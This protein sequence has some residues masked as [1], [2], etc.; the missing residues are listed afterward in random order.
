MPCFLCHGDTDPPSA[1]AAG[2]HT[3][4][5]SNHDSSADFTSEARSYGIGYGDDPRAI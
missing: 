5:R 2:H 4:G 1:L 3:T